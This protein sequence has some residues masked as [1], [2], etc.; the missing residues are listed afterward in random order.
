VPGGWFRFNHCFCGVGPQD[1]VAVTWTRR[2]S[3]AVRIETLYGT[4]RIVF[5]LLRNGSNTSPIITTDVVP[6]TFEP[7]QP[8][9][10]S[11]HFFL[12]TRQAS[13]SI[14][15][16]HCLLDATAAERHETQYFEMFGNRG[17]YDKGGRRLRVMARGRKGRVGS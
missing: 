9:L 6:P 7:R 13:V 14:S 1:L 16:D 4:A 15:A 8:P 17:I 3:S 10:V 2:L 12:L 5:W 11:W